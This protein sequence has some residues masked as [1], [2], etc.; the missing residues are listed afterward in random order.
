MINIKLEV[1]N[2][3]ECP[4]FHQTQHYTEDSFE[5]AFDWFCKKADNKKISGY[6]SW[7]EE[8]DIDIPNWCPCK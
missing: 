4:Y 1:Q 2:C 7:N 6:V 8:K 3:T 5:L